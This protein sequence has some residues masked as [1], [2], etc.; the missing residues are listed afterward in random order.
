[1][2]NSALDTHYR[3]LSGWRSGHL[4]R[5]RAGL[6]AWLEQFTARLAAA[7]V[8]TPPQPSVAALGGLIE[9]D[10]IVRMYVEQ[11]IDQVSDANKTVH[12]VPQLL[13]ALDAI[14][15]TAPEFEEDEKR[16]NFFP[17]SSLFAYMMMTNAGEAA[18]RHP[19]FNDAIRHILKAWC[20]FLDSE[21]SL[22]VV[23]RG[24]RGWLSPA[25][26]KLNELDVF[27][28]PDPP[29]P[30]GGFSSFNAYFH[31]EIKPECRPLAGPNDPRVITSANDGTVYAIGREV[32]RADRFWLKGQPYSL[33]NM[34]DHSPWTDRFVGGDVLQ[35]FLSGANYHRW[36]APIGGT[37]R[38]AHVVDGLMFS[39]AE[40]AGPDATAGTYSQGYEC[41]VNTRGLVFIESPVSSIGMVCVIPIGITEVSSVHIEVKRGDQVKKGDELGW[42]SYGGSS[43]ALVFEK[44]AIDRFT[45]PPNENG[46]DDGPPIR[47]NQQVA[48]VR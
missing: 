33:E 23:N 32:K 44:G 38:D 34:L 48:A 45:V 35:S 31:R 40:S 27:V 5:E 36:R 43:M 39:D 12:S 21:A 4:P 16:R 17:M 9:R 46:P 24:P 2:S 3:R 15:T 1:M 19:P 42:F 47:V 22:H 37:V 10:G 41:S 18:F 6:D 29:A 25:A 14:I 8:R 13:H 7:P 20:R 11:M 28:I 26:W 30:H